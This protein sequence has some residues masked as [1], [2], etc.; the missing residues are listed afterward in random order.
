MRRTDVVSIAFVVPLQGPTGIYGPSCLA[1]GQLAVEQ[2][3]ARNGI[4][5]RQIELVQVDAGRAP[6]VV[7]EEVGRLVDT[8]RV[9][10]VAGWHISA[11]RVALTK[12]IGGRV[13]YAFAAMHEGS[14]DTPGVFML[15]ERPVN[16]L[17]PATHWLREHHGARR[18]VVVGNDY[19]YPRVTGSVAQEALQGTAS[20]IVQSA[21][22]PL[23]TSDFQSVLNDLSDARADGVIMLLMGQDAVHFNRQFA[24]RGL[25]DKLLRLSPA[26]EEN[27]LLGA[28]AGAND[29]MYAAAAYFDGL[30]TVESGEFAKQYYARFGRWAPALNAVGESCYE[31]IRF[32]ARLGE[33]SGSIA[34]TA[35]LP[36]G[37]FYDSPRGLM[38]L[39]GNLVDQDVYLATA[40]GLEFKIQEQIAHTA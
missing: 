15:G 16:Q 2:L 22:I 10:A 5:G 39:D 26:I 25:S 24:R 12:R 27:T 31:A 21:Y 3:N 8:G 1:C 28:G 37:H 20:E 18:W 19:V 23:G 36:T 32:L 7:A 40:D 29:N 14:D 13:V 4:A 17:L 34:M 33:V 11:V 6:E 38:R 30:Q 35:A 9:D